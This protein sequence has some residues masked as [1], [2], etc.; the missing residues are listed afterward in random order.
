MRRAAGNGGAGCNG[1]DNEA[2]INALVHEA[3]DSGRSAEEVC[4]H[5]QQFLAQVRKKL[6]RL[7]RVALELNELFPSTVDL[8]QSARAETVEERLPEIPGYEFERVLGR[9]GMGV[10][11]KARHLNLNRA[12]A[13]KMLH[14]GG[15]ATA[16][17][18]DRLAR[19][20]QAVAALCHPNI[21]MVHDV[22]E[23]A[24]RPYFTMEF[25]PGGTLAEHLAN[26]P[27][28][29]RTAAEML[30]ILSLAMHSAHQAGVVHR[31]LKPANVLL[32]SDGTPKISDFGLARI[33]EADPS[34]TL[35]CARVGTPS[36]MA[37]EQ[38]LGRSDGFC[39]SVD[40]YALGAILYELLTG[41]PP[42]R[43][44]SP[45]ETQRQVV[46]QDPAPP[47]RLN[48]R[49]PRDLETICLKCLDKQPVR[50]YAS[51]AALAIDLQLFLENRP[52]SARRT[53]WVVRGVKWLR[54]RPAHALLAL[55]AVASV[56]GGGAWGAW[57]VSQRAAAAVAIRADLEQITQLETA[58]R[59]EEAR[60]T[61]SLAQ[62]RLGDRSIDGL[63]E[64]L[65]QIASEIELAMRL[66]VVRMERA[67]SGEM[68]FDV[69]KYER[70]YLELLQSAGIIRAADE[71]P[72]VI[73]ERIRGSRIRKT[74][75]AALNEW[76]ICS[77]SKPELQR[78]LKI[79]SLADPDPAWRDRVRNVFLWSDAAVIRELA[80]TAPMDA[81]TVGLAP[82]LAGLMHAN[83]DD[84]IPMLRRVQAAN[85]GDF[86]AN[87]MLADYLDASRHPDAVGFYRAARALRPDSVAAA[88]NLGTAL[89]N[90]GINDEAEECWRA[91][92]RLRPGTAPALVNIAIN[93]LRE[94]RTLD[95]IAF[96]QEAVAA[97]DNWATTHFVLADALGRAADW[98]GAIEQAKLAIQ[99][100]QSGNSPT[101]DA[102]KLL[103]R[104]VRLRALDADLEAFCSGARVPQGGVEALEVARLLAMRGEPV[105]AVELYECGLASVRGRDLQE[106]AM[107]HFAAASA[108]I[109]AA[110]SDGL[111]HGE[112]AA[113]RSQ[114]LAWMRDELAVHQ[115]LRKG[116]ETDRGAL[117][118]AVQRWRRSV[119][120]ASVRDEAELAK[121]DADEAAAW[122]AF[123]A[124][125]RRLTD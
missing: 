15:V 98:D 107:Q 123:W 19:E 64:K 86:W 45:L 13:V 85:P 101:E 79:A 37:P 30:R 9:G 118:D 75:I 60:Q 7:R 89:Q 76:A 28:S 5:N 102:G 83:G 36:Y 11:F 18:R 84:P 21:V 100:A 88:V 111:E 78:K 33:L 124:D 80:R 67:A 125:V 3:L 23:F 31:D 35:G 93:A 17:E 29:P 32:T 40:V 92:L 39:P 34:Q 112:R 119:T 81:Q 109:Q 24:G 22:G 74:L 51:A 90:Q 59:W 72:H 42:F 108:A 91:A 103:D 48:T 71:S 69:A 117:L 73:A 56:A 38:A 113:Y 10:V 106:I 77:V 105:A 94:D 8:K 104:L 49:I 20:A 4:A 47:T 70:M 62:M 50:R 58:G 99:R 12:V 63:D 122:R 121:L 46:E 66:D 52:I 116:S 25:L 97:A 55:F 14:G 120:M 95:A 115:K 6:G 114:A 2:Q 57:T 96:A 54:R 87:F 68:R 110:T 44:D 26:T 53:S 43:A 41:R 61:L 27:Q 65:A 82:M 16:G 1:M